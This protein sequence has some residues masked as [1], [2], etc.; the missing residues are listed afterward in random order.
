MEKLIKSAIQK[1]LY[2][3]NPPADFEKIRVGVAYYT[4][5]IVFEDEDREPLEL[6]FQIPVS[7]M[8][9]T[10]FTPVMEAKHLFR[11]LVLYNQE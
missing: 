1:S 11:W 10:D 7:E 3:Q 9:S 8:G 6:S 4:S 5:E 2:K